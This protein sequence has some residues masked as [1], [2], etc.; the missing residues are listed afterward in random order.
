IGVG[1]NLERPDA[2]AQIELLGLDYKAV[3]DGRAPLNEAQ[4]DALL[5]VTID[6]AIKVARRSVSNFD[7]LS[8]NRQAILVDMAFTMPGEMIH[9]F[10]EFRAAVE[11]GKWDRAK[12]EMV[13]S[14]WHNQVGNRAPPM[15]DAMLNDSIVPPRQIKRDKDAAKDVKEGKEGKEGKE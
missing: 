2:R 4:I 11:A 6:E 3:S 9:S 8:S 5:D 1:F 7:K 10:P 12:K 13:A 14:Q 15:E